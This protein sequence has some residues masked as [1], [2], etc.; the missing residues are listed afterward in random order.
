MVEVGGIEPPSENNVKSPST[1]VVALY[2][3]ASIAAERQA[4][5]KTSRLF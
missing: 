5:I 1:C 3:F 4:T 2:L